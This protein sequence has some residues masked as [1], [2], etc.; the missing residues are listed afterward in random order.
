MY[1]G[2]EDDGYEVCN[3]CYDSPHKLEYE[4]TLLVQKKL[5]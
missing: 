4:R 3:D 1:Y 5:S 2:L